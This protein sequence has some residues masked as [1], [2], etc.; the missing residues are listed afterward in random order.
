[1]TDFLLAA[2]IS[3]LALKFV[4]F[5]GALFAETIGCTTGKPSTHMALNLQSD[6]LALFVPHGGR[7][8]LS[9]IDNFVVSLVDI[10][11]FLLPLYTNLSHHLS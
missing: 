1:M 6:G 7:H 9:G 4:V 5:V 2:E 10:E 3:L 8:I 11:A